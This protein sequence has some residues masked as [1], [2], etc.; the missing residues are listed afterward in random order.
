MAVWLTELMLVI[1]QATQ[2]PQPRLVPLVAVTPRGDVE[3][4]IDNPSAGPL[5]AHFMV[6]LV[7]SRRD[8]VPPSDTPSPVP[9]YR[10]R[11]DLAD[12]VVRATEGETR[13]SV[14]AN[15]SRGWVT[16][17]ARLQ[18]YQHLSATPFAPRSFSQVVPPGE[19]RLALRISKGESP[20]W[21]SNQL[22]VVTDG[23]GRLTLKANE[24]Q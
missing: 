7:L 9:S 17:A 15:G 4:R 24:G 23:T 12:A 6:E 18:W 1:A 20:W 16:S 19:Y 21:H 11:L 2:Q 13:V 10:A 22:A 14:A 3:V 8:A 5:D